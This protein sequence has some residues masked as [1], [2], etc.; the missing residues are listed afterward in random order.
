MLRILDNFF[1]FCIQHTGWSLCGA[2]K[3]LGFVPEKRKFDPKKTISWLFVLKLTAWK[4]QQPLKLTI[5]DVRLLAFLFSFLIARNPRVNHHRLVN[6]IKIF[7]VISSRWITLEEQL[8]ANW[9]FNLHPIHGRWMATSRMKKKK[10]KHRAS[11][12]RAPIFHWRAIFFHSIFFLPWKS[13]V[14]N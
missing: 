7:F 12:D 1:S 9:M 11:G 6:F 8:R 13:I 14:N 4:I 5:S 10:K 3:C 2:V